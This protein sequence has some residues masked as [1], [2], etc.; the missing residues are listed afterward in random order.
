MSLVGTTMTLT[1]STAI[2]AAALFIATSASAAT[3]QATSAYNDSYG[4]HGDGHSLTLNGQNFDFEG[5]GLFTISGTTATLTGT[6][7]QNGGVDGY[8]VDMSF[9]LFAPGSEPDPKLELDPSAYDPLGPV[10]PSTWSFWDLIEGG[11][12]TILGFGA[13]DDWDFNVI[14][15]PT[16]DMPMKFAFQ[17]GFGANGK[18]IGYGLSGWLFLEGQNATAEANNPCGKPAEGTGNICDFNVD[19]SEVPLPAPAL[20]LIG[21]I[22]ALGGLRRA[23]RR[24]A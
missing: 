16:D 1:K 3:Y 14:S 4:I 2:A 19:L 17:S 7:S 15:K 5:D 21:G 8:I 10:D 9:N 18:N 24:A 23:K 13:Y 22:A 20:L 6:V 11:V 12:S